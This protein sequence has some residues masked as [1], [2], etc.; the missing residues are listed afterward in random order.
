MSEISVQLYTV[1]EAIAADLPSALERI[2]AIG[3][4]NV[5]PYGFVERAQEYAEQLGR[6]GLTAPSAHAGMIGHDLAPIF[7]AASTIGISTLID[8]FI[9]PGLWTTAEGV[10]ASAAALNEVAKAAA[11][12]GLRV[13]YHNHY[14]ELENRIGGVTALEAFA[15]QLDDAVVLE[16]DTYW[17]EVGGVSA[18]GLLERLGERVRFIHVK[19]GPISLE[20]KQQVAVGSGRVPVLEILAAAPQALRVVELDDFDGDIFEALADSLAF[21]K[22]NGVAA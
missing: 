15:D 9:D 20:T 11:D 5:E 14:W 6:L 3:F 4:T 10:A 13:G 2:A 21:L 1:R 18:A 16:V 22:N 19:D 17:S 12:R 8:P 7:D